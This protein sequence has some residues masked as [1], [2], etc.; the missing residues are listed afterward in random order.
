MYDIITAWPLG[1]RGEVSV[2]G[3]DMPK[4]SQP[5]TVGPDC[6]LGLL[7]SRA[8]TFDPRAGCHPHFGR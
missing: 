8:P 1:Q 6:S 3:S 7:D 4:I 5:G 2:R